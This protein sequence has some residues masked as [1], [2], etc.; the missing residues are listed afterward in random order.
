MGSSNNP[1][2]TGRLATT[3]WYSSVMRPTLCLLVLTV[4]CAGFWLTPNPAA[5][6]V[7]ITDERLDVS[8]AT[9]VANDT[10][11]VYFINPA[12]VPA[13]ST[14]RW[15]VDGVEQTDA[16]NSRD[17][18][19]PTKN[20]G[21]VTEVRAVLATPAGVQETLTVT[22]SPV[23]IDLVVGA[24]SRTPRF[25]L[26][27]ALPTGGSSI[28]VNALVF[29][30][31]AG[32]FTYEWRVNG[33][34]R[35][36]QVGNTGSMITFTP[37]LDSEM[38]VEVFVYSGPDLVAVAR[39]RIP[40]LSPEIHFYEANPLRGVLH[41]A[42]RSPYYLLNDEITLRAEPFFFSGSA[43]D[44][45]IVWEI[46]NQTAIPDEDPLEMTIT[47]TASGGSAT[48]EASLLNIT[49]YAERASAQLEV[50]Y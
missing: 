1:E 7:T 12:T 3:A 18:S 10:A 34:A 2:Q 16:A 29:G 49:N 43:S 24:N 6:R 35:T 19:V 36:N 42:L 15:F 48:I 50:T 26:G 33:Q 40:L 28:S 46:E 23:R 38:F 21:E 31:G 27:R 41:N 20:I 9:P 5:A 11:R 17:V 13:G 30:A 45:K 4:V 22:I 32:P 14:V 25:Y 8:P 44:Y 37:G 39:E 47:K